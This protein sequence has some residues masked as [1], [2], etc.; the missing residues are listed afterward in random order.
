[1]SDPVAT[2]SFA[3]A[4]G[5]AAIRCGTPMAYAALGESIA[6]RAGI[7]NLGIEGMMLMGAMT[8]VGVQIHTGNAALAVLA[9]GFAA[10]ALAALHAY[11]TIGLQGSQIVSGIAISILGAGLSGFLGRP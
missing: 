8:A 7:I 1:M 9:A 2:T 4:V 11:I 5:A 3:V 6:E 10:T